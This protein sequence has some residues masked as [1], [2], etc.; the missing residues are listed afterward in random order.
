MKI[1]RNLLWLHGEPDV[2]DRL[3]TDKR[4]AC[5]VICRPAPEVCAVRR[6]HHQRLVDRLEALGQSP[7][8]RGQW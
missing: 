4:L 6:A 5:L 1:H 2:L 7:R 8:E 3:L